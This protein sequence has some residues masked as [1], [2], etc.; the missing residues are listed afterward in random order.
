MWNVPAWRDWIVRLFDLCL[1]QGH[2]PRV[3]RNAEVIVIPKPGKDDLSNPKNW[4]PISLLSVL[5]KGI[6]RLVAR[7]LAFWALKAGVTSPQHLGALPGRSA[8]DLVECLVHDI[9]NAWANKK[10][11]TLATVDIESAFDGVQPGRLAVRLREQGWPS[12][13]VK[14]AASFA[15]EKHARFRLDDL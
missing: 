13:L 8:V 7:R 3:F 10:V 11:C 9:E 1:S 14:W 5:G 6:E 15:S 12:P 4:R 2:H